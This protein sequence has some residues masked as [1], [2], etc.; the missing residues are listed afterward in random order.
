MTT[1]LRFAQL[2]SL[3]TWVGATLFVGFLLAPGVFATLP[4]RELA[5]S[6]VGMALARLHLLGFACAAV[7]WTATAASMPSR[8][9]PG[10]PAD[11]CVVLM[12]LV[13]AASHFGIT[14]RLADLRAQMAAAHGSIDA[15]PKDDGLRLSF[16]RLHGIANVLELLIL[17]LG[18]TA[19]FLTVRTHE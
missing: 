5:G 15:T 18:L 11:I 19:L 14:P 1:I 17:L 6:V 12:V 16:G 4:T 8:P 9:W 3:G 10:R 2:L 7:Y 13:L